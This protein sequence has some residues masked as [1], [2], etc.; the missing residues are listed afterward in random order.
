MWGKAT[1]KKPG[2]NAWKGCEKGRKRLEN[3]GWD[4]RRKAAGTDGRTGL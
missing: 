2:P 3:I 1:G 4:E